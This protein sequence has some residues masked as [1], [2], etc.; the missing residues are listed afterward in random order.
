MTY[1]AV[2]LMLKYSYQYCA[3]LA[4]LWAAYYDLMILHACTA[5]NKIY[6]DFHT[7]LK[8]SY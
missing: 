7:V 6:D 2:I 3:F 5:F 8:N 4:A 1:K